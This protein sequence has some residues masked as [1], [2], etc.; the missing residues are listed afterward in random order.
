LVRR[1]FWAS[2]QG[3]PDTALFGAGAYSDA[4]GSNGQ[5]DTL[6]PMTVW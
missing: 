2:A 6:S 5:A 3:N 4:V 1:L